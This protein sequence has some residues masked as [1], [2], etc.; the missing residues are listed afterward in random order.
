[1]SKKYSPLVNNHNNNNND[2]TGVVESAWES[3]TADDWTSGLSEWMT[4]LPEP[5]HCTPIN[6]LAIPG[7]HDSGA[8]TF[9]PRLPIAPDESAIIRRFAN[10][11]NIMT[12][13][14]FQVD[15]ITLT[16]FGNFLHVGKLVIFAQFQFTK[17]GCKWPKM[18][19][20]EKYLRILCFYTKNNTRTSLPSLN[21]KI[22]P[23]NPYIGSRFRHTRL[24]P[25]GRVQPFR[26]HSKYMH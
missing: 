23:F 22:D 21:L 13:S 2:A 17:N 4:N 3:S 14:K 18:D 8:Y 6:L 20:F 5:L 26:C 10:F 9:D 12:L 15:C 19:L 16:N 24:Q 11:I 1:M 25:K 7:S